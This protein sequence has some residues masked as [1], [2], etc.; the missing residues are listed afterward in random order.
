MPGHP[1]LSRLITESIGPEWITNLDELK[2]LAPLAD[3]AEFCDRWMDVKKQKK[4]R[5]ARY[6]LRKTGQGVNPDT[7]FDVHVK[8]MHEY[9]RQLLNLLHV[10]TLY[11]RI[12]EDANMDIVPRTVMFG[13]KAG[14]ILLSGKTYHQTDQLGGRN[15]QFGSD[16]KWQVES[17][18]SAELLH[19]TSGKG[20]TGC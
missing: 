6:I 3:D 19:F 10:V 11:E 1:A 9:K 14:A 8:R 12:R 15:R 7:L 17:D 18:L 5:L 13:G 2:R 4:K 16:G 20:Y